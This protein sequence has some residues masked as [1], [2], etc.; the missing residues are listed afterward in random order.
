MSGTVSTSVPSRSKTA[1]GQRDSAISRPP[2][3]RVE[4]GAGEDVPRLEADVAQRLPG[5]R[6]AVDRAQ[7]DLDGGAAVAQ[8]AGRV[9]HRAAGG[10]DVLDEGHPPPADVGALGEPARAVRLRLLA[11]ED[12]GQPG[13]AAEHRDD[14]DAAELEPAEQVGALGHQRSQLLGHPPQQRRVGLELVLVEVLADDLAGP[15]RELPGHPA[16]GVDVAGQRCTF[17]HGSRFSLVAA[18]RPRPPATM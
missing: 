10:D 8:L 11:H 2:P 4:V 18:S 15:Q 13:E 16:G 6:A 5:L 14:R 7:H 12:R 9:A 1:A 17:T 3:G